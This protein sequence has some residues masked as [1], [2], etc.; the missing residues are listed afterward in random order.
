MKKLF[1]LF[2]VIA[3]LT[4]MGNVANASFLFGSI[5]FNQTLLVPSGVS[6]DLLGITAFTTDNFAAGFP[7][8]GDFVGAPNGTPVTGLTLTTATPGTWGF[9]SAAFGTFTA[10]SGSQVTAMYIPFLGNL[11][12]FAFNGTFTPGTLFPGKTGSPN[13]ATV[14]LSFTQTGNFSA[15]KG[16][17][18]AISSSFTLNVTA[19]KVPEPSSI[20]MLGS[21]FGPAV[22]V[23]W[24]HR[25]W[26]KK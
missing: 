23:G 4:G 2:A 1:S 6:H 16:A 11:R 26:K 12:T 20:V 10:T 21:V 19:P 5:A 25:R 7:K 22:V 14:I 3:L 24:M 13:N 17:G 18:R 9:G 15:G 8:T